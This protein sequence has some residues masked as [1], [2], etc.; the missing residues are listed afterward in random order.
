MYDE[1]LAILT[2]GRDSAHSTTANRGPARRRFFDM[3]VNIEIERG[4]V[5]SQ[6]TRMMSTTTLNVV[7]NGTMVMGFGE[8][9]IT[10]IAPEIADHHHLYTINQVNFQGADVPVSISGK[11]QPPASWDRIIDGRIVMM[12]NQSDTQGMPKPG[13][14]DALIQLPYPDY[15]HPL[16]LLDMTFDDPVRNGRWAGALVFVYSAVIESSV[17]VGGLTCKPRDPILN[18]S[19]LYV[20]ASLPPFHPDPGDDHSKKS[21]DAVA[22]LIHKKWKWQSGKEV[23]PQPKRV[24]GMDRD[25]DQP[26]GLPTVHDPHTD[27]GGNCKVPIVAVMYKA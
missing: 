13:P 2:I 17:V 25:I 16:R 15:I 10:V 24:P 14:K 3:P 20:L 4:K 8:D 9:G 23:D 5:Q 12:F 21:W 22:K 1:E 26:F 19:E 18:Y 11:R 27:G 7:F 6:Q